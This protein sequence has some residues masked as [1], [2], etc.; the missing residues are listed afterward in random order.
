MDETGPL[1]VVGNVAEVFEWG[2]RV[3]KLYKSTEAKPAEFREAA[4]HAAV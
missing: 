3:V 1:L 2:A 4:M